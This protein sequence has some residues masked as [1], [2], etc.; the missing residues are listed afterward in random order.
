MSLIACPKP[1][2][3][4]IADYKLA[5]GAHLST[6][7]IAYLREYRVVIPGDWPSQSYQQQMSYIADIT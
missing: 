7:L 1:S 5:A 3:V 2:K 6:P 4:G